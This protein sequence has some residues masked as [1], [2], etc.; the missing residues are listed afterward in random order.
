MSTA[1]LP[2]VRMALFCDILVVYMT[3]CDLNLWCVWHYSVIVPVVCMALC[4][5][6]CGMCGIILSPYL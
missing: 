2:A 4:D 5:L 3:F 1:T 6:S